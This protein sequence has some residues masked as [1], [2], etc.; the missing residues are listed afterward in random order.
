[1]PKRSEVRILPASCK[2]CGICVH[3]C[4]S[5]VLEMS[6]EFTA[7]GY[8][9]PKKKQGAECKGCRICELMCP[10]FAIFIE[11]MKGAAQ[12]AREPPG[13]APKDGAKKGV[14]GKNTNRPGGK[15]GGK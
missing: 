10:D 2:G 9:P 3:Y 4:P 7:R 11:E 12:E 6:G 1:M 5:G 13:K 8:H 15:G 14:K